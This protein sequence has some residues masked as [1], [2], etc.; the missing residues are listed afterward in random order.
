MTGLLIFSCT[1]EEDEN[2][3]LHPPKKGAVAV[4]QGVTGFFDIVEPST[5]SISFDLNT[6]GEPVTSIE[7]IMREVNSTFNE[8]IS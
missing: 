4:F 3:F 2:P 6:K 7:T 8:Y 5:S 1:K